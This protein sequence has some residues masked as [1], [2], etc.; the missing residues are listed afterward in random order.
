MASGFYRI[1]EWIMRMAYINILWLLFTVAGLGVFGF[2]PATIGL[3]TV[4]RKWLMGE[5]EVP[6]F[7]TFLDCF[8]QEFMTANKFA[9]VFIVVG[10]VLYVDFLFLASVEG[11]IHT[12]LLVGL[13]VAGMIYSVTLCYIIPVYVHYRLP[14]L[15]YFKSAFIIGVVNPVLT[16]TMFVALIL[17]VLLFLW[18]PGLIP[19]FSVS[20]V[21]LVLMHVGLLAIKN[22]ESKKE[23]MKEQ[24]IN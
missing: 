16:I 13:F 9:L 17:F 23:K 5:T 6:I 7:R 15:Q 14:F 4:V 2:M 18:I 19:F 22:I 8:K 12:I 24:N 20:A 1:C 3:F 21:G 10:F 11:I